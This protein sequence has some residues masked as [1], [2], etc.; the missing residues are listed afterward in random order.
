MRN[1]TSSRGINTFPSTSNLCQGAQPRMGPLDEKLCDN[2]ETETKWQVNKLV[3]LR[4]V[5]LTS[6]LPNISLFP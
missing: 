1:W 4:T 6:F 5:D 3:V 2:N